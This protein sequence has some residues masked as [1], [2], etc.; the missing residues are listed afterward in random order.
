MSSSDTSPTGKFYARADKHVNLA[1]EHLQSGDRVG[2]TCGSLVYAASRFNAWMIAT[3][4]GSSEELQAKKAKE[5]EFF[6][7]QYREMLEQNLD[8]YIAHFEGLMTPQNN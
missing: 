2:E 1:N 7:E 8:D 6:T 3:S 5:L 4:C